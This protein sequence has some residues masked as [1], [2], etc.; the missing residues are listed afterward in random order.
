MSTRRPG[1]DHAYYAWSPLPKRPRLAWPGGK[2]VAFSVLLHLEHW[3]LEPPPAAV[4]D[5]RFVSEFGPFSPD[6]RTWSQREYGN[7]V[8]IARVLRVLDR[9]KIRATV[10]LGGA[11]A[12]RYP[13]LVEECRRRGY[14]FVAHGSHATR[15]LSSKMDEAEERAFIAGSLDAVER[16]VGTR[17]RGWLGQ[18]H[19]ESARTPA[20]LAEA[21]LDHVLDW[22][23]DDQ[24]YLMTTRPPLVAVP[25]Q[26]EWDDVQLFWVRR[27]DTWRYP[28]LVTEALDVLLEEG[29]RSGRCFAL[30]LHPW[31][32]GMAH[33]I[34]YLDDALSAV[35]ARQGLWHATAGEI[36]RAYRAEA[37]K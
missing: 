4:K 12:E 16:A 3:E 11:A 36:A 23:N 10:A 20:L 17:P 15:L 19:G 21:G 6:Y 29:A 35:T 37:T 27:A 34:R 33:R 26:I 9:H 22:A 13:E 8:G 2:P 31:L 30:S 25:N 18:D 28:A 32:F 14:E 5:P 1:M 7:R 24:P